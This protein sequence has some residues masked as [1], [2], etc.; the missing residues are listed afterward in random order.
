MR[1]TYC[2]EVLITFRTFTIVSCQ[3][4][5]FLSKQIIKTSSF[6][7][8]DFWAIWKTKCLVSLFGNWFSLKFNYSFKNHS[9]CK[10]FQLM[11]FFWKIIFQLPNLTFQG[12]WMFLKNTIV[13]LPYKFK[14]Q[15]YQLKIF[16]QCKCEFIMIWE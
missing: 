12:M 1:N 14:Q 3:T 8:V 2:R 9:F 13:P 4:S 7:R 16:Y 10:N 11:F 5:N 15:N 6:W